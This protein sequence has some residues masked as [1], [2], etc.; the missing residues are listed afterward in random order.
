MTDLGKDAR[1]LLAETRDGDDP[2]AEDRERVRRKLA[3]ALAASSVATSSLATTAA[4]AKAGAGPAASAGGASV[5]SS[6]LVLATVVVMASGAAVVVQ[7]SRQPSDVDSTSR[8]AA[9]VGARTTAE[10]AEPAQARTVP[11][12]ADTPAPA[13]ADPG[14]Q[15]GAVRPAR[16]G[17]DAAEPNAQSMGDMDEHIPSL[18]AE[19]D[20][21]AAAQA[22]LSQGEPARA[23]ARIDE[24]ALRFPRG[25]FVQERLAIIAVAWCTLGDRARGH[26]AA[27]QLARRAPSSPLLARA[28]SACREPTVE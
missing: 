11:A 14:T 20:L 28:R 23:L 12:R 26:A 1:E 4:V 10:Q 16:Q 13:A 27:S 25:A 2:S 15:G 24:H 17:A 9:H 7:Q 22:A 18:R 19:L 5:L 8:P 6:K 3:V 21:I